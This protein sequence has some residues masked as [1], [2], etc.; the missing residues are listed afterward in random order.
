[1]RPVVGVDGSFQSVDDLLCFALL[2]QPAG[3]EVA[4]LDIAG[5]LPGLVAL[6]DRLDQDDLMSLLLAPPR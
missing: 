2:D 4:G 6:L 1:V 3:R 5:E